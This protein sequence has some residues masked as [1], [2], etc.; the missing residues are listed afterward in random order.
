MYLVSSGWLLH[1][2]SSAFEEES[3]KITLRGHNEEFVRLPG[4][5]AWAKSLSVDEIASDICPVRK[6]L[7]NSKL[8]PDLN[9]KQRD[10]KM[11]WGRLAGMVVEPY[12]TGLLE[13]FD[14]LYNGNS[15]VTYQTLFEAV[16]SHSKEFFTQSTIRQQLNDLKSI[17]SEEGYNSPEHLKLVLE[18][19]ARNELALLGADFVLREVGDQNRRRLTERVPIMVKKEVLKIHP[20]TASTGISDPATPDFLM[21]KI[22]AVGDVKSGREFKRSHQVTCAGYA[23]ARES[24]LGSA[25]DTNFG[26]IYFIETHNT[27]P[28]PARAYFFVISDALRRAFLDRRNNAYEVLSRSMLAQEPPDIN[29]VKRE[30]YCIH[31]KFVDL[32]DRDRT[33]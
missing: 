30:E 4:D 2:I 22:G 12:C 6:D 7:Y 21:N 33:N 1:D 13:H 31:C 3:K 20:K 32:C 8:R 14:D 29:P 16:V 15:K 17:A 25:G 28:T 11:T 27:V 26:I 19:S 24:E 5:F 9:R 18:Y 23:L 10:G